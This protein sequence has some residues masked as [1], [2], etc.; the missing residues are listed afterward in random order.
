TQTDLLVQ[1]IADAL[2][3][4]GLAGS[5]R[6]V[7]YPNDEVEI[8]KILSASADVR[9]LWGGDQSVLAVRALPSKLTGKDLVFADKKS[10]SLLAASAIVAMDEPELTALAGLFLRDIM[11]FDQMACSSPRALIWL[12]DEQTASEAR[13]SWWAAIERLTAEKYHDSTM[14]EIDKLVQLFIDASAPDHQLDARQLRAPVKHV[15]LVDPL[16]LDARQAPGGGYVY[17]LRVESL[18]QLQ[19]VLHDRLQTL[20]Y[21]GLD[22]KRIAETVLAGQKPAPDRIVPVGSALDFD[23]IWDGYD[24][25]EELTRRVDV[26]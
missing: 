19:L 10:A 23:L 26:K 7:S 4:S 25:L 21:A 1:V 13:Q 16:P 5:N 24:L 8:T 3:G 15:E 12:G 2:S 18:D 17:E 14:V 22:G 6:F 11:T 20:G 9:M